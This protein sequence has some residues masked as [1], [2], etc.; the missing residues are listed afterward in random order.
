MTLDYRRVVVAEVV[1][2][3]PWPAG[4]VLVLRHGGCAARTMAQVELLHGPVV[5]GML[6]IYTPSTG[7]RRHMGRRI[8]DGRYSAVRMFTGRC[9]R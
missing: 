9:C 4:C 1:R 3:R 5:R 8:S 2:R 6:K 7:L